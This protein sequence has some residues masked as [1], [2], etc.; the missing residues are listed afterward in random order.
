MNYLIKLCDLFVCVILIEMVRC[1][2]ILYP[3]PCPNIFRYGLD[4][5]DELIGIIEIP[6]PDTNV[7]QLN[8]ELS[9][10]NRLQVRLTSLINFLKLIKL[11]FTFRKLKLIFLKQKLIKLIRILVEVKL[12]FLKVKLYLNSNFQIFF[13]REHLQ[14]GYRL[15]G[16]FLIVVAFNLTI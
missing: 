5:Y 3:S 2:G 8:I 10:G 12:T 11:R 16:T 15:I 1:A 14:T 7:L 9:V 6:Y 13:L 4:K